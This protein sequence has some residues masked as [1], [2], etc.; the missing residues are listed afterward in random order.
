MEYKSSCDGTVVGT[1]HDVDV[2]AKARPTISRV[3]E[4][5]YEFAKSAS[6]R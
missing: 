3:D 6:I 2:D 4:A 1:S 5:L